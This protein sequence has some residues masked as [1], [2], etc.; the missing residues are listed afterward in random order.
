MKFKN[1]LFEQVLKTNNTTKKE[2]SLYS[3]IPYNTVVGW[4]KKDIVPS[5][6]M[7]ILKDMNYRKQLELR[8][9]EVKDNFESDLTVKEKN[10]LLSAFWG[11]NYS[12]KF[13]IEGIQNKEAK[14]VKKI[15]ENLSLKMQKQIMRKLTN[16]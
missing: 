12:L 16:A 2:F 10:T 1:T 7:V 8:A 13:I 11:T 14:I 9:K 3:K 4:K 5:Y 6:T 15:K